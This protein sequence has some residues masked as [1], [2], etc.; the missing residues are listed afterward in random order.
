M[1]AMRDEKGDMMRNAHLLG[2]FRR[3]CRLLFHRVRPVFVFDGA[4]PA[5]KRHTNIARRRRRE[6]Q[7][8][9]LR[10]TAE[11]LLIAQLKKQRNVGMPLKLNVAIPLAA[12]KGVP[13]VSE[14]A[15]AEAQCA[16]L[17]VSG[18][19]DGV[20]T[21]DN[22]V[23]LFGARHVYRHIFE[24]KKYVEEY[25]MSD[26]ERELGLTRERLAEMAL[27]LGSDYT[28][29]CGGIGI[30]NAVEVVQAF[31]GLE[32]LQRFRSWVESPDVGI[33]AAARQLQAAGG[34]GELELVGG[35][36]EERGGGKGGGF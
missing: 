24:N 19:V 26:V 1:K 8:G 28:E 15:A 6:A 27:L 32:G 21:D 9:V 20:V 2:F 34:E 7:Q 23:F 29:G 33:V 30:V 4:T 11:K 14:P 31:P 35:E 22:D 25:Q 12:F 16:F 5:L 36:G 10:K 17:E 13:T 18:L 3:I